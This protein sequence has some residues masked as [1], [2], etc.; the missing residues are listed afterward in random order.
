[1]CRS[2][3]H[4]LTFN[5]TFCFI[6]QK[7]WIFKKR[8]IYH[9]WRYKLLLLV[10]NTKKDF[11][12]CNR[13]STS[14][15][16]LHTR[17]RPQSVSFQLVFDV[18]I[19]TVRVE[20]HMEMTTCRIRVW[21]THFHISTPPGLFPCDKSAARCHYWVRMT[22]LQANSLKWQQ[23][24]LKPEVVKEKFTLKWALKY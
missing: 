20:F 23:P 12:Y 9:I 10:R 13:N 16:K 2:S 22:I 19:A 1:M 11:I 24:Y 8:H 3:K 6:F 14:I 4:T 17:M 7:I 21:K 5:E 15:F 18:N